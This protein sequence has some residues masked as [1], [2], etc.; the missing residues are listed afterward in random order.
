MRPGGREGVGFSPSPSDAIFSGAQLSRQPNDRTEGAYV[1]TS[2]E[3]TT[4]PSRGKLFRRTAFVTALTVGY[5]GFHSKPENPKIVKIDP[6]QTQS[7][8]QAN[9]EGGT[10]QLSNPQVVFG[11]PSP[12]VEFGPEEAN[13]HN[14]GGCLAAFRGTSWVAPVALGVIGAVVLDKLLSGPAPVGSE[15][16]VEKRHQDLVNPKNNTYEHYRDTNTRRV[17]PIY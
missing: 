15:V 14:Y 10:F 4:A 1:R 5:M 8:M 2:G 12:A 11:L 3:A 13:A 7:Y 16:E 17:T 9:P 6:D